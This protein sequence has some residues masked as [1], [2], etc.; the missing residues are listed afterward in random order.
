MCVCV[1]TATR[2]NGNETVTVAGCPSQR[3][4][5]GEKNAP[6]A[7]ATGGRANDAQRDAQEP[8]RSSIGAELAATPCPG[9]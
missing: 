3:Q 6:L 9:W 8:M 5:R 2:Q 4:F 1:T 7:A